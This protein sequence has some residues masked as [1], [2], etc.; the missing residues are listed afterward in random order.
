MVSV[1]SSAAWMHRCVQ[2]AG[3]TSAVAA[4]I[5]C[6]TVQTAAPAML[7]PA[8]GAHLA[9]CAALASTL[10]LD[11][12]RIDS[13]AD[14]AAGVLKLGER[15]VASH[16][17]VTGRMAERKGVDGRDYA[18]GFEMRLPLA[19]NGRFYYQGNGGLDGA[20]LPW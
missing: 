3:V 17:W 1:K 12:T 10:K 9:A 8:T 15:S 20:V 19:W 5:A 2:V 13:V 16:C 4:L 14:V 7:K 6:T 18:I 11:N